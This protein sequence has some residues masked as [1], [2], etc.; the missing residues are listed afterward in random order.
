MLS[1]KRDLTTAKLV[2]RLRDFHGIDSELYTRINP[3]IEPL[4]SEE[5]AERAINRHSAIDR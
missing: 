3:N 2:L 5:L 1:P 4:T